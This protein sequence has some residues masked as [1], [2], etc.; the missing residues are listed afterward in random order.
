LGFKEYGKRK[1]TLIMCVC[2]RVCVKVMNLLLFRRGPGGSI[3]PKDVLNNLT[4]FQKKQKKGTIDVW[5]LYDD[6]GKDSLDYK[7]G[8]LLI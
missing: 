3:L 4:Q 8:H 6:G 7:H 5:W 2:V 1:T